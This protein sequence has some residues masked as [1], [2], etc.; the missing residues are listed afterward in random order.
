[1]LD[2]YGESYGTFLGATYANLFP[3]TTGH[4][5][6]DGNINPVAWTR[7]ASV[8]PSWLRAGRDQASAAVMRDFLDLCGQVRTSACAFSAGSPAATRA[9]WGIL[10][11]RLG[12]YPVTRPTPVPAPR[13]TGSATC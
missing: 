8:L 12:R 6:L 1:V 7:T 5:I 3:A 2:Y 11:D 9:K 13:T 10:L 4:M